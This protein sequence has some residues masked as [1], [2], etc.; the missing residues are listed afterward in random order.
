[1]S[2]EK[3]YSHFFH[4][5][6]N[7]HQFAIAG[8]V[9]H[10]DDLFSLWPTNM[11]GNRWATSLMCQLRMSKL[12][13]SKSVASYVLY[14]SKGRKVNFDEWLLLQWRCDDSD[15]S[16]IALLFIVRSANPPGDGK[17]ITIASRLLSVQTPIEI[18]KRALGLPYRHIII[19]AC[20]HII[21]IHH[22]AFGL[23]PDNNTQI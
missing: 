22:L 1:M 19:L 2:I 23:T 13:Y 14:M 9:R 15:Y 5:Q 21:N 11:Q 10:L 20:V 3:L 4:M 12:S 7:P 8:V 17:N 6:V 18:W 16:D